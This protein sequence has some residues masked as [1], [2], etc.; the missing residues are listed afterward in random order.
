MC[1]GS[2]LKLNLQALGKGFGFLRVCENDSSRGDQVGVGVGT[3]ITPL[4][5]PFKSHKRKY[6]SFECLN[7]S[8][9]IYTKCPRWN[10]PDIGRVFLMLNYIDT[11]QTTY[12]QS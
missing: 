8:T 9:D 10:V 4:A 5:I 11:S 12:I 1:I 3:P 7:C 6:V 2:R